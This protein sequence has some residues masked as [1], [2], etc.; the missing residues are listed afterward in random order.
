MSFL[1]SCGKTAIYKIDGSGRDTYIYNN[2]GGFCKEKEVSKPA[3][4][5]RELIIVRNYAKQKKLGSLYKALC[6]NYFQD[7][8]LQTRW[9]RPRFLNPVCLN[10]YFSSNNGGFTT[11][12]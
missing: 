11:D 5:G 2:S 4:F 1:A 3:D 12:F 7:A 10:F 6:W 9:H 8:P